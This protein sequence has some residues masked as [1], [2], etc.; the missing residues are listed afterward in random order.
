MVS[1]VGTDGTYA[2][3]EG[4]VRNGGEGE[5]TWSPE[6]NIGGDGLVDFR[7]GCGGAAGVVAAA[8]AGERRKVRKWEDG[9][10]G[11]GSGFVGFWVGRGFGILRG[12]CPE[13]CLG[14]AGKS[15]S[16]PVDGP[17]QARVGWLNTSG[18]RSPDGCGRFEGPLWRYPCTQFKC[19]DSPVSLKPSPYVRQI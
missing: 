18:P 8:M 11:S 7:Q 5:A 4:E 13:V 3:V 19:L 2:A 16:G 17:I 14:F 6:C 9:G 1:M 12:C 10:A 15:A